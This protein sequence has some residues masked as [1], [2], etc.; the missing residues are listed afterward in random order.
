MSQYTQHTLTTLLALPIFI[1][2]LNDP[3]VKRKENEVTKKNPGPNH[4]AFPNSWLH[5]LH[6][7]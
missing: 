7:Q 4:S 3:Y 2:F 5:S 6:Q 1:E